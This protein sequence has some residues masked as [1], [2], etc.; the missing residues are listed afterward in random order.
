MCL[1][2]HVNKLCSSLTLAEPERDMDDLH[3]HM[4]FSVD[5][6]KIQNQSRSFM[7][8]QSALYKHGDVFIQSYLF[9]IISSNVLLD[10]A[11]LGD[12]IS[13]VVA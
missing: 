11:L 13:L 8:T 4:K 7:W 2:L 3:A 6:V 9:L 12:G 1:N 10:W 5:F